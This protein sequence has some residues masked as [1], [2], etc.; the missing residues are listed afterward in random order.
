MPAQTPPDKILYRLN[1]ST[2][3]TLNHPCFHCKKLRKIAKKVKISSE[4]EVISNYG[5][6]LFL[7]PRP[8]TGKI[9]LLDF[10]YLFS[11]IIMHEGEFTLS[12]CLRCQV[13]GFEFRIFCDLVVWWLAPP[14]KNPIQSR[15]CKGAVKKRITER[16]VDRVGCDTSHHFNSRI[17]FLP[18]V[19][20]SLNHCMKLMLAYDRNVILLFTCL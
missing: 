16:H 2:P 1:I 11:V 15:D 6:N 8:K 9:L 10:C 18:P 13:D 3:L 4:N 20:T 17:T 5:T 12:L 7:S 14:Y 19:R